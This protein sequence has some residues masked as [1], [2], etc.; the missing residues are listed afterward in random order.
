MTEP[1]TFTYE[2][3]VG[4]LENGR[5]VLVQIFRNPDTLEVLASQLA[6]KTIAGGTWQTPYQL[7]KL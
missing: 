6:F 1:Q 3:F 7:E 5:E 2:A 4:K